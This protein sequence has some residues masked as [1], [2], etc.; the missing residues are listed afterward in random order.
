MQLGAMAG[1][2][3]LALFFA[4][5]VFLRT[6]DEGGG[7]LGNLMALPGFFWVAGFVV[8]ARVLWHCLSVPCMGYALTDNEVLYRKGV[9]RRDMWMLS[10]D[11]I[12]HTAV[13]QS[14]LDRLFRLA[15]LDL[16][17]AGEH[18]TSIKGLDAK[19]A[20]RLLVQ[21]QAKS[22]GNVDRTDS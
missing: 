6:L 5:S 16:A 1:V 19:E 4:L 8:A 11:R 9:F 12:H 22:E 14:L 2:L 13:H 3:Y 18:E 21:V 15:T 20:E 17:G 7:S 10:L